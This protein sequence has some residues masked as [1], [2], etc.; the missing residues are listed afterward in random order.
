MDS[1]DG[2]DEDGGRGRYKILFE[3]G[4]CIGTG[5]CAE[6]SENWG[7]DIETGKAR[8]ENYFVS[9][10]ELDDNLDAA[11][12]CPAKNGEG[13]IDILDRESGETVDSS[14]K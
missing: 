7:M 12:V 9:E 8:P 5:R 1:G 6:V 4:S 14:S 2:S 3:G 13:V 10:E 11:R